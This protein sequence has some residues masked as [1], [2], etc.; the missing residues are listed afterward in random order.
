MKRLII[1]VC[2]L[3]VLAL[4]GSAA[5]ARLYTSNVL[6]IDLKAYKNK[7]KTIDVGRLTL[8]CDE[9]QTVTD[10]PPQLSRWRFNP[11]LG[12]AHRKFHVVEPKK[13]AYPVFDIDGNLVAVERDEFVLDA[14]G[15]FNKRYSKASGTVRIT[16]SYR[17]QDPNRPDRYLIQYHNC[18]SGTIQWE[19]HLFDY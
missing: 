3:A 1:S 14:K 2:V 13:A 5:A 17:G 16:G 18:D 11:P 19:A 12:L 4:P 9:G 10:S 6:G 8:N 15:R 7:L